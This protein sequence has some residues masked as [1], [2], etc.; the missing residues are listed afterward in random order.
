[1]SPEPPRP[2]A[3]VSWDGAKPSAH[4]VDDGKDAQGALASEFGNGV[5]A[6]EF[7]AFRWE[8]TRQRRSGPASERERHL[9]VAALVLGHAY[10]VIRSSIH[11]EFAS[12]PTIELAGLRTWM[13]SQEDVR[14]NAMI[15][16]Q[17]KMPMRF[18][19]LEIT[20][21][22]PANSPGVQVADLL[23]WHQRRLKARKGPRC[24]DLLKRAGL[25]GE[26]SWTGDDSPME[27][28]EYSRRPPATV[29]QRPNPRPVEDR[30]SFASMVCAIERSVHGFACAPDVPDR[31]LHL[32]PRARAISATLD[33]SVHVD[34]QQLRELARVFLMLVD[35]APL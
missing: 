29:I 12:G 18:P 34:H 26:T 13:N 17:G 19:R 4:D 10:R 32:L 20:E 24:R 33:G 22:T 27:Y 30:S 7:R 15:H 3:A 9:H 5:P 28:F 1:M 31:L 2:R 8:P 21:V 16:W 25:V 11:L 35:T 6:A 23:L 14:L